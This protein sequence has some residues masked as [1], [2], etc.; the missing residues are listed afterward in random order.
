MQIEAI[1]L[2]ETLVVKIG[3]RMDSTNAREFDA[4]I[5]DCIGA[6]TRV[7]IDLG[8]LE[9]A[10]S[11]GLRVLLT[12]AKSVAARGGQFTLADAQANVREVLEI[13]G[14]DTMF[15]LHPSPVDAAAALS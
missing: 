15:G 14:F 6:A 13:T 3:P 8:A 10:S 7:V 11:A 5:A 12:V 9:Y 2:N 4:G 1:T